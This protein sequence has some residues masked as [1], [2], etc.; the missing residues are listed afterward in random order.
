MGSSCIR[1]YR[2]EKSQIRGGESAH[3]K[4]LF[5]MDDLK[6][7]RFNS[8]AWIPLYTCQQIEETGE[9]GY[10]GYKAEFFGCGTLAVPNV[11]RA[12]ANKLGWMEIGI[13]HDYTP[14]INDEGVYIPSDMY[15]DSDN[16]FEGVYLVLRENL[17]R[18]DISELHLHQD[19]VLAL[20]LKREYDTWVCPSEGYIEV[21]HLKRTVDGTPYLFEVRAE[22][23]KDYLCARKM[24]LLMTTYRERKVVTK[25]K[26]VFIW[27]EDKVSQN[28]D[29]ERWEGRISEIHEGGGEPFGAEMAVFHVSRTDVDEFEDIPV[30]GGPLMKISNLNFGREVFRVKSAF[31][32]VVS[33]GEMNG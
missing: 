1:R 12:I 14:W 5:E 4:I 24:A 18:P 28:S 27:S 11:N 23:L 22:Y 15:I 31:I 21:A 6:L 19:F 32:L 33:Y 8:A 2:D 10:D 3:D 9:Y 7:R 29:A 20:G 30:M 16:D 26:P 17:E 25:N 13:R